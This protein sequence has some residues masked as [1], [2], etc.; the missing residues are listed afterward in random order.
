M[1]II[2]GAFC[3]ET[4]FYV[5]PSIWHEIII[6]VLCITFAKSLPS[7]PKVKVSFDVTF[8]YETMFYVLCFTI[9]LPQFSVELF[10]RQHSVMKQCFIFYVL[11]FKNSIHPL[12]Y[13]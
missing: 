4:G 13:V 2:E 8:C 7:A 9:Y 10:L 11:P 1:I 6:H 5:L 3:H 12:K